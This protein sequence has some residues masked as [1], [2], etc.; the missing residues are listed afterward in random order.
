MASLYPKPQVSSTLP[1]DLLMYQI[2]HFGFCST[3]DEFRNSKPAFV[4][5]KFN[6]GLWAMLPNSSDP[7]IVFNKAR[8][9]N[10]GRFCSLTFNSIP[11]FRKTP[12]GSR[13]RLRATTSSSTRASQPGSSSTSAAAWGTWRSSTWSSPSMVREQLPWT[14]L[15]KS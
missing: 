11:T 4:T 7:S 3:T 2:D 15:A 6:W 5:K 9:L 10:F 1:L 14:R 13:A 12:A 8:K